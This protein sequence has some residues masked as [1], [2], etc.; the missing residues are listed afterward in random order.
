MG[1]LIDPSANLTSVVS[2]DRIYASFDG[3]EDTYLRVGAQAHQGRTVAV[4]IGLAN[5]TGFP[6]EGKLEFVDNQLDVQTGAV[7]MR[8]IFANTDNLLVPGLFA[9]VQLE[10]GNGSTARTR[11]LLINE[12]AVGTDQ[13]HKFVYVIGADNKTTYR[14]VTLGATINGQ[15][16]VRSGLKAGERIVVDGLQRVQ[17]GAPITPRVVPM[18]FDPTATAKPVA[19]VDAKNGTKDAS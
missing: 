8:A 11:A 16:I 2:N 10:G 18:E 13:S 12:R 17:P 19:A 15:R 3:D 9:R 14:E 7:R 5:E 1:N 4:R 6:H